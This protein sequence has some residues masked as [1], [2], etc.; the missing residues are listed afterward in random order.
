MKGPPVIV[1]QLVHLHGP[2]RGE[3]Q[4]FTGEAITIGRH[5]E[6]LLRGKPEDKP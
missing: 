3:I 4:E 1:V 2:L 6:S 5:P